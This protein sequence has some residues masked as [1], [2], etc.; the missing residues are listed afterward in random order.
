MFVSVPLRG[1]GCETGGIT[2][3]NG[4]AA[5]TMFPSPCGVMG[6]KLGFTFLASGFAIALFPSPC[7]VMGVKLVTGRSSLGLTIVFPS[8][9][10]VMGVKRQ[11]R[12]QATQMLEN[13]SVPLRGNGCETMLRVLNVVNNRIVLFPSPCGV[14]GV[15]HLC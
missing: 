13:V 9:C 7:G 14:M 12:F 5:T 11:S 8:P 6:V 4:V 3:N 1:N 15:K 2:L 10:G